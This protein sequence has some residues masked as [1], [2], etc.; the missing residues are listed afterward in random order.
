MSRVRLT[1]TMSFHATRTTGVALPPCI[2]CNWLCTIGNSFGEC[3][4]SSNTQSNPLFDKTYATI[5]D[6][7]ELQMPICGLP[8]CSACL[9][10]LTGNSIFHSLNFYVKGECV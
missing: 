10:L 5:C 9:N 1:I 8:A 3:S 6:E 7:S 4:V 2:A